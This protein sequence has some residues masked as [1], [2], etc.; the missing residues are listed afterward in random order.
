MYM[1]LTTLLCGEMESSDGSR[2]W[3]GLERGMHTFMMT[4]DMGEE[5]ETEQ[6]DGG[7]EQREEE[8]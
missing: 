6:Y 5:E 1:M 2:G 7:M 8:N 4:D 3:I